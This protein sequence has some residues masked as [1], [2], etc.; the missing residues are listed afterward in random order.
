MTTLAGVR[1]QPFDIAKLLERRWA[2]FV[3]PSLSDLFFLA[4][5]VWLFSA[6]SAGWQ[7]LLAD[8]DAGWHIRTGEYVLDHHM[9]PH[10]DLYSFSKP[11]APWYAWEWGTDVID[12]G[13]HRWAG[14]KGV[15]L[16]AA[17]VI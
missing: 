6:G 16:L 4:I 7:S 10:T 12:A 15:V 5:L 11:D 1:P 9:V 13:L 2:R 8:A 3:I 14:L 17:V